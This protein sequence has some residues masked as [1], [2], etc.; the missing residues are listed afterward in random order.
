MLLLTAATQY[1]IVRRGGLSVPEHED[2]RLRF[3]SQR[4]RWRHAI[5]VAIPLLACGY[6]FLAYQTPPLIGKINERSLHRV[7]TRCGERFLWG[8]QLR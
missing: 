5:S 6:W 1:A 7:Y 8:L 4:P 3:Y 2:A